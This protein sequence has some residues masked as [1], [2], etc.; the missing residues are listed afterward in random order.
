[1]DTMRKLIAR[2]AALPI[3]TNIAAAVDFGPVIKGQWGIVTGH[4]TVSLLLRRR[5]TYGCTFLGGMRVTA[6][7]AQI[8]VVQHGRSLRALEDPFWF[9]HSRGLA[10]RAL[11]LEV[12]VRR[13][14][15][16]MQ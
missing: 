12:E 10:D 4:R 15:A 3:G 14:I 16:R 9:L 13:Y 1:M 7:R 11:Q 6:A 2:F 5:A 8:T